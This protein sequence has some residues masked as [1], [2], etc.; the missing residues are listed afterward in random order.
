MN[1]KNKAPKLGDPEHSSETDNY[2][3]YSELKIGKP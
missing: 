1:C 3:E 2:I